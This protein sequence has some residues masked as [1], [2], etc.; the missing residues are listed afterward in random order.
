MD[1][2]PVVVK[3]FSFR[4]DSLNSISYSGTFTDTA[5]EMAVEAFIDLYFWSV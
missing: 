2:P 4:F 3:G 5:V 1:G